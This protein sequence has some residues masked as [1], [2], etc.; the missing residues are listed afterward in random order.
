MS[1]AM[2]CYETIA[3][4]YLYRHTRCRPADRACCATSSVTMPSRPCVGLQG[5]AR[6]WCQLAADSIAADTLQHRRASAVQHSIARKASRAA[7]GHVAR[8]LLRAWLV[9]AAF[10][11]WKALGVASQMERSAEE[12][13]KQADRLSAGVATARQKQRASHPAL[14]QCGPNQSL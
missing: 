11:C 7:H 10:R 4:V 3:A 1:Y 13:V 6:R 14:L 2:K 5:C 8:H 12:D 9:Q